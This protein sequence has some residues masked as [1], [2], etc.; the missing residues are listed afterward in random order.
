MK[1][2]IIPVRLPDLDREQRVARASTLCL[3]GISRLGISILASTLLCAGAASATTW[4]AGDM[5]TWTQADWGDIPDGTN[6]ASVL[7]SNYNSVYAPFGIFEIGLPGAAGFS[8][9]FSASGSLLDYLPAVGPIGP[10]DA[11]LADPMSS[12]SGSFGGDVAAL[13]LNIDFADAGLVHG[14]SPI[15]LGDLTL[16]NL[17]ATPDLNNLTVRQAFAALNSALAGAPTLD[18]LA[19]LD[20]LARE[21]DGAFFLGSPSTFAQD[22]LAAP[23]PDSDG[24]GVSDDVDNCPSVA[25]A[26]QADA[27]SDAVGNACDNCV[28]VANPRVAS[29]FL[30]ANAWATLTGG[31]RD[32]DHDGY[33][34]KCDGKFPGVTGSVV[35]A[36][37]LAQF[38]ASLGK[39]LMG[40]TCG[41]TK[42]RPCAI[43]DLDEAGA[44]VNATDLAI[45]RTLQG[46]VSGP[47]CPACPID[48][49]AG[50][51]GTCGLVP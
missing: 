34:N 27:D 2:R 30:A 41:T 44:V 20:L 4:N 16:H 32:D 6:I 35:G 14:T 40:D 15:G 51:A 42:T 43:F 17:T 50:T 36:G 29:A 48:C 13:K 47:K 22:H 12:A 49:A 26:N 25:N 8:I 39:S 11:D 33:G 24:D 31:Q 10:L 9:I 3:R 37:D 23:A 5:V 45:F 1:V 46:K 28:N 38:R 21:L 19:D 7:D 18:T